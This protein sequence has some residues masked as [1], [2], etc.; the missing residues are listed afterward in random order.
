MGE[1]K[2]ASGTI[3]GGKIL[4]THRLACSTLGVL[5][6]ENGMPS[7]PLNSRDKNASGTIYF[8]K[9]LTAQYLGCPTFGIFEMR[10][11]TAK[12]SL[13]E[14]RSHVA[15]VHSVGFRETAPLEYLGV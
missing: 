5:G 6:N 1:T 2:E 10:S 4:T 11:G 15:R 7:V 12:G 8:C 13:N 14:R 3:Y 9:A